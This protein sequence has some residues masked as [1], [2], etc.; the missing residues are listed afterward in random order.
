MKKTTTNSFRSF[1]LAAVLL[2]IAPFAQA[3]PIEIKFATNAIAVPTPLNA[4]ETAFN[5]AV[6]ALLSPNSPG[7]ISGRLYY[8]STTPGNG[9][10]PT[11][12]F[13]GAV[14]SLDFTVANW[15][16]QSLTNIG[17]GGASGDI[18]VQDNAT[19]GLD[20]D[21]IQVTVACSP[22]IGAGSTCTAAS[23]NFNYAFTDA[24]GIT[25]A[26][27]Q[28]LLT[29]QE[30][31]PV[32]EPISGTALPTRDEWESGLYTTKRIDLRFNPSDPNGLITS[33]VTERGL[34]TFLAVPE[35]ATLAL[36]GLG[37]LALAGL[38]RRAS[39]FR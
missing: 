35:P 16:S 10:S 3:V 1:A 22:G 20:Q 26:L 39:I 25:W 37:L 33:N 27:D 23:H 12:T 5:A 6:A 29:L 21:R 15:F 13:D 30:S 17:A 31:T 7:G 34:I 11:Q 24:A 38:Q 36:L 19:A 9:N 14:I 4:T 18:T 28:F 2:G 32:P 8:E